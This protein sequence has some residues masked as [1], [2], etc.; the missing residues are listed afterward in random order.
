MYH[1]AP[2][3]ST[4]N[5]NRPSGGQGAD[6]LRQLLRLH[7]LAEDLIPRHDA[8]VLGH[9][10]AILR[11]QDFVHLGHRYLALACHLVCRLPSDGGLLPLNAVTPLV[12]VPVVF[13]VILRQRR[14]A[15]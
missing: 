2:L 1:R 7:P 9:C 4:T 15:D 5:G 10:L 3:F 14:A 13:Y 12:G 11:I 8:P 6:A